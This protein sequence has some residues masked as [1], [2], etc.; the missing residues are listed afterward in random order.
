M[1]SRGQESAGLPLPPSSA[2]QREPR[3]ETWDPIRVSAWRDSRNAHL[4]TS[5]VPLHRGAVRASSRG[6]RLILRKCAF[7][8]TSRDLL[9]QTER[10]K[11]G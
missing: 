2:G 10:I 9:H 4:G 7:T 6:I 11:C 1:L 8:L 5:L 3:V